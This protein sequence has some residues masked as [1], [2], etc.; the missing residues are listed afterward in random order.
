MDERFDLRGI[1]ILVVGLARE[2]TA[3]ACFLAQR[4]AQVTA[5]DL[6]SF[7]ALAETVAD[8]GRMGVHFALGG[9]PLSLLERADILFVSPGVPPRIPL[10]EAARI[11]QIP[12]SSE[13]RLFTRLCPAPVIGITG[14]SGKTTTTRLVGEMLRAGGQQ[15]WVGGNIGSPLIG[16][17]EQIRAQD[18]VVMEL[19]SF[20]LE[21]FAPWATLDRGDLDGEG[22][23]ALFDPPG[24]SPPVAA[25]LNVT[26]D[27]MDYHSDMEEY[28]AAKAHILAYQQPGDVAVLGMDN[29]TTRQMAFGLAE[30]KA[31]RVLLFSV[32]QTVPEGAYLDDARLVLRLDGAEQVI[33]SRG[34]LTMLGRHNVLNVLAAACLAGAAGTPLEAIRQVATTFQG[35]G[36]R[37]ELIRER[38]GVRWYND[39]IAT[40]PERAIAALQAFDAPLI[41]LAGGRD[42][43]LPWQAWAALVRDKVQHVVLFGEAAPLLEKALAEAEVGRQGQPA[44]HP[45]GTLEA[46]VETAARLAAPGEVVLLSPGGTSFDAYAD[47]VARGEHFRALV[48]AL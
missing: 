21:R 41:L 1:R 26:P 39:S 34:A 20:Q 4:G 31:Q 24:W 18:V 10:L 38:N 13:T 43:H 9:H 5:T 23:R 27:H 7:E 19:S 42:K 32:E 48:E 14:S 8:L 28:V 15:T 46:A 11:R 35:V 47:Y 22:A 17:L 36:H 44:V 37:L 33:C 45:A 40:S 2:G 6:K 30:R 25:I 29:A 16:F 3:V 12:L